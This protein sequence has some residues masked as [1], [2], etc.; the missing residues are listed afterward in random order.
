LQLLLNTAQLQTEMV[1]AI[2]KLVLPTLSPPL[3]PPSI[4]Q[5]QIFTLISAVGPE[6]STTMGTIE[7]IR[8]AFLVASSMLIEFDD[9]LIKADA[10]ACFQHLH[11]F[12]PRF[13]ELDRLVLHICVG[14]QQN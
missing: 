5:I 9:P 10:V 2:A 8:N 1:R 12:A 14:Q 6:L 13:V 3:P 11:L 7:P 4:S